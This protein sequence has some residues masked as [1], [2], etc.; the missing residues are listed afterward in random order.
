MV[1]SVYTW[2]IKEEVTGL[3]KLSTADK[4]YLIGMSLRRK[5]KD[6]T[7][8]QRNVSGPPVDI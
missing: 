3:K 5:G 2:G 8:D 1:Y 7:Q 4:Q 6:L